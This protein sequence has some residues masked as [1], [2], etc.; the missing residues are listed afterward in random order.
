MTDGNNLYGKILPVRAWLNELALRHDLETERPQVLTELSRRYASQTTN[1]NRMI[2]LAALL[3]AGIGF[4]VLI[5]RNLRMRQA[6][7][8]KE[9]F[10]ADLHD[11][12]GANLHTI[13]LLCDLAKEA[14]DSPDEL[15][16]LLDRCRVF[17]ERSGAAARNCTNMLEAK[18]LCE[19]LVEEMKRSSARLLADLEHDLSFEGEEI[20]HQLNPRK[21]I[22]LFFFYKECLTNILRH[23]GA[24]HVSARIVADHRIICLTVGDNGQGIHSAPNNNGVPASLKRRARLLGGHISIEHPAGRGTHI[25]LKLKTRRRFRLM[26]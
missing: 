4:T 3:A 1:L 14:V 7:R 15:I 24:T 5:D 13:G 12:L 11:E 18:G 20:L 17:T 26:Q 23:S 19:D 25:T 21:R 16:E 6:T 9:R 10:A 8:I 22:D 2:W